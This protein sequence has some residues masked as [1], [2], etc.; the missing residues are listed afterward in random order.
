MTD[1]DQQS[2]DGPRPG[3]IP[4]AI[5][6]AGALVTFE[7][8]VGVITAIV[9]V[10]RALT[11]HDQSVASGAGT[12]IWF[13]VLFGGV[14]AAGV[15]LLR[16]KRWGRAIAVIAQVLLLPVAW[17]LLTDSHQPLWGTLLA[18]V[19]VGALGALFAPASSRYMAQDYGEIPDERP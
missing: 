15:G 10:V 9:L 1:G 8:L 19:V 5:R 12:A 16:G 18:I 6:V 17:S 2:G 7:G 13:G 11:G 14:L 3:G 4:T